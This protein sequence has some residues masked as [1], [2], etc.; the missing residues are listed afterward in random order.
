MRAKKLLV[1]LSAVAAVGLGFSFTPITAT[2]SLIGDSVIADLNDPN[3]LFTITDFVSPQV[4]GP[5]AEFD[6]VATDSFNQVWDIVLDVFDS[7]FSVSWT[8]QT[9]DGEGNLSF[10]GGPDLISIAL[11]DLDW[12]GS[13]GIITDVLLADYTCEPPGFACDTF[14]GGPDITNIAFD[15][16]SLAVDFQTLRHGETYSFAITTAHV[17]EPNIMALLVAGFAGL[18]FITR[19][20][21]SNQTESRLD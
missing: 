7:G 3:Q 9:R 18:G 1:N 6:A 10:G 14:G 11:S 21:R 17:S 19:R 15:D 5:G 16:H 13:S 20:R 2:A 8:E 4:V 12:V